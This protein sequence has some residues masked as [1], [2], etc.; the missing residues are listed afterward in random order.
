MLNI[1]NWKRWGIA[2]GILMS[3]ICFTACGGKSRDDSSDIRFSESEQV[4]SHSIEESSEIVPATEEDEILEEPGE[5]KLFV[6]G[7]LGRHYY[8]NRVWK[9]TPISS[10]LCRNRLCTGQEISRK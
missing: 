8:A 2:V 1:K 5:H 3:L 4:E 7:E 10:I 6:V 9:L